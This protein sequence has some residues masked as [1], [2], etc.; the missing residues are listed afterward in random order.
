MDYGK[1]TENHGK[2]DTHNWGLEKWWNL[3][4]REKWVMHTE[5]TGIWRENW[6]SQKMKITLFRQWNMTR[7]IEKHETW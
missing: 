4:K 2:W 6:K 5:E 3:E 1:K 7:N